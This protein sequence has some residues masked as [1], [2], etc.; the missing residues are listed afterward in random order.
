MKKRILLGTIVVLAAMGIVFGVGS[1]SI[2]QY[3]AAPQGYVVDALTGDP[4]QNA[5]VTLTART[6]AVAPLATDKERQDA[7]AVEAQNFSATTDAS[8]YYTFTDVE[9]GS[10][11]LTAEKSGQGF[12]RQIVEVA[13]AAQYLPNIGGVAD[14]GKLRIITMWN[15]DFKDVDVYLTYYTNFNDY[16]GSPEA[17]TDS[18]QINSTGDAGFVPEN[19][20]TTSTYRERI[21]WN[22]MDSSDLYNGEPV[23]SLDVDN[24]G[25]TDEMAGG[26]ETISITYIPYAYTFGSGTAT[27]IDSTASA[28][29]GLPVGTYEWAGA[30]E[31]YV[32]AYSASSSTAADDGTLSTTDGANSADVIVFVMLGVNQLGSYALPNFTTIE[33]ASMIRINTFLENDTDSTNH[34]QIVPDIRVIQENDFRA[35]GMEESGIIHVELPGRG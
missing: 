23:V 12:T 1:C 30:M 14:D 18:Y 15:P 2:F 7:A 21:F 13:G 17:F 31:F 34:F 24:R 29:S 25:G 22:N 26:P 20:D 35:L 6:Q 9:Y 10:Y 19:V 4:I 16:G 8:G 27:T 3:L 32:D 28:W 5:N 11:V 33:N